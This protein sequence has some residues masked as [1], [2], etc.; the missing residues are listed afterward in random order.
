MPTISPKLLSY[1]VLKVLVF[2]L[3]LSD[4]FE[5]EARP[6]YHLT[7]PVRTSVLSSLMNSETSLKSR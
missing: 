5:N 7:R 2:A 1:F 4:F 3:S 6:S